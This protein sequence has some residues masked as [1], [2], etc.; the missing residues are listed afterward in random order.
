LLVVARGHRILDV[1][2]AFP[3]ANFYAFDIS[4]KSIEL[5]KQ[6]AAQDGV[7]NIAFDHSDIMDYKADR[8]FDAPAHTIKCGLSLF[9]FIQ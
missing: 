9:L 1:A 5:A 2:K 7:E 6:Q 8:L 3:E 4:E